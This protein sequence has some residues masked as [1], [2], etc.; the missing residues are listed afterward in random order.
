MKKA[1]ETDPAIGRRVRLFQYRVPEEFY[2]YQADPDALHNLIDDP[3]HAD[4]ILTLKKALL[5]HLKQTEDPLAPVFS[6]RV[7][8]S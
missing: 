3:Q 4:H 5:A 2:D 6:Q 7:P 8:T 1:A